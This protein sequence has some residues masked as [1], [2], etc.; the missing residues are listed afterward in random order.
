MT[1]SNKEMQLR[2][3]CQLYVYLL[4]RIGKEVPDEVQECADS[5]D[6]PIDCVSKLFQT[7]ESLDSD[8]YEKIINNR[9]SKEARDLA[10]WWEM[11]QEADKLYKAL[12]SD[13]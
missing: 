12:S 11:Y 4:L 8:T 2:K 3:T 6:Y 7:V 5:Y 13:K 10:Y 9:Q 1:P